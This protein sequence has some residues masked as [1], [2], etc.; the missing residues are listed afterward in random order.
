M[1]IFRQALFGLGIGAVIAGIVLLISNWEKIKDAIS[2]A[3]DAMR[4]QQRISKLNSEVHKE[5]TEGIKSEVASLY[6]LLAVAKNENLS[7][8]ERQDAIRQI[9]QNYPELKNK[10]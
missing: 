1:L 4:E 6:E 8:K 10:R 2:G 7:K 9:N 3:T 5:A